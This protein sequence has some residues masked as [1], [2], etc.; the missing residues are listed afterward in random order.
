M[1]PA[2]VIP[3]QHATSHRD[4]PP[5]CTPSS[6]HPAH[7]LG[8]GTTV[9]HNT[10]RG[11]GPHSNG[12]A[13]A[14]GCLRTPRACCSVGMP[15]LGIKQAQPLLGRAPCP[16]WIKQA[17]PS[18]GH[19]P[20]SLAHTPSLPPSEPSRCLWFHRSGPLLLPAGAPPACSQS[21]AMHD[22]SRAAYIDL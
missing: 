5:A 18:L 19:S 7:G 17:Q 22:A 1:Q 21:H 6:V 10:T 16:L 9:Q 11:C 20:T 8:M 13:L 12:P 14:G 3:L 4:P 2:A 15:A